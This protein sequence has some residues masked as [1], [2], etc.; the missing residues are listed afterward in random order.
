MALVFSSI[1]SDAIDGDDLDTTFFTPTPQWQ[2][3][4]R[5]EY[6]LR[7]EQSY[8]YN[9]HRFKEV[10]SVVISICIWYFENH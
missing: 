3:F 9:F 6:G 7:Q 2:F 5:T 8:C 1:C 4:C 10:A